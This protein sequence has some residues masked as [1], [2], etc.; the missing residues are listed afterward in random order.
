MEKVLLKALL[1][2]LVLIST[3]GYSQNMDNIQG[4]VLYH[5]NLGQGMVG[6]KAVLINADGTRIDSTFTVG[7]GNYHFLNVPYGTYTIKFS[8]SQQPTDITIIDPFML[9]MYLNGEITLSE[10]EF[11]A[12]DV[13]G[14]NSVTWDDYNLMLEN[15]NQGTEFPAG[16]W[17]FQTATYSPENRTGGPVTSGGSAS[18][19]ANGTYIPTKSGSDIAC[20]SPNEEV[21]VGA[22]EIMPLPLT[23]QSQMTIGGMNLVITIPD[24][25]IID[26][27]D[28]PLKD[29]KL[30]LTEDQLRITWVDTDKD[31]Q[32]FEMDND[33]ALITIHATPGDLSSEVTNCTFQIT[34]ESQ[35]INL[36]GDEISGMQFVLP[37]LT[38]NMQEPGSLRVYP[39][40]FFDRAILGVQLPNDGNV[41]VRLFDATGRLIR[42]IE[43]NFYQEGYHEIFIDGSKLNTGVYLYSVSFEGQNSFVKTG[44]IIKSK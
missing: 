26:K 7:G 15:I 9:M 16:D 27:I 21:T 13:N 40:P 20:Q 3:L 32:G 11:L 12:C 17:V 1:A 2:G 25:L 33:H 14:D 34:G 39:N 8:S 41:T 23:S 6:V 29:Y 31:R 30:N 38:L 35:F 4:R 28:S 43:N 22:D 24:G 37:S 10:I 42:Q 19:D 44:T 36:N 5:N 18:G